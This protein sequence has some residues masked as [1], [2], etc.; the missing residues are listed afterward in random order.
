MRLSAYKNS[1]NIFYC[2]FFNIYLSKNS[3]PINF[4]INFLNN[5]YD[6]AALWSHNNF[7]IIHKSAK[8]N[9]III[10]DF[11]NTNLSITRLGIGQNSLLLFPSMCQPYGFLPKLCLKKKQPNLCW[12]LWIFKK[13]IFHRKFSFD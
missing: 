3:Y 9:I 6:E 4:K 2:L 1:L 8:N 7:M 5:N 11:M 10:S 13:I 12:W